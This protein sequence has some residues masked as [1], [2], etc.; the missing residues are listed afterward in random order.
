VITIKKP[1]SLF[2]LLNSRFSFLAVVAVKL[3]DYAAGTNF[4][5]RMKPSKI[6]KS[7]CSGRGNPDF[8]V[9]NALLCQLRFVY[10][11]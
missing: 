1:N 7:I 10:A 2:L 11:V 9:L 4:P 6:S 3:I 5:D 8:T